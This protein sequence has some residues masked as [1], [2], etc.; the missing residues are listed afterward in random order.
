MK[1]LAVFD[2]DGTL[3]QRDSFFVFLKKTFSISKI[4]GAAVF[5]SPVMLF[6]KL[7]LL[8][9]DSAKQKVLRYFLKGV[10]EKIIQEKCNWFSK[11]II[12]QLISPG[13][14]KILEEYA[15]LN[16]EIVILSASPEI[17]LKQWCELNNF[18]CI[19]T[20]L[21]TLNGKFT[22]EYDGKNCRGAEKLIRLQN[23]IQLKNYE[24]IHAFG[25][26]ED[27]KIFMAVAHQQFFGEL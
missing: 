26:S 18:K 17:Y 6:Y 13:A 10:D 4:I 27:D 11:E 15:Q 1:K 8:N 22:G 24:E 5:L 14:R 25:N 3:T 12:P 2:F 20:K 9:N 16:F 7:K 23:E 21:K 19:S